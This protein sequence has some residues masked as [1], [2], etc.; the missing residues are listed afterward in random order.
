MF[1]RLEKSRLTIVCL[2]GLIDRGPLTPE[3]KETLGKLSTLERTIGVSY[4]QKREAEEWVSLN[5]FA[6]PLER[7]ISK[8]GAWRP[9]PMTSVLEDAQIPA[10][11]AVAI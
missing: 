7:V 1:L 10:H 6:P 5:A 4:R 11:Q 3:L 9:L 8:P 2:D